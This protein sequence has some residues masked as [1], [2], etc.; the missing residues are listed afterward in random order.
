MGINMHMQQHFNK[1]WDWVKQTFTPA[2]VDEIQAYLNQSVDHADLERRIKEL[3]Q[4]GMI[5]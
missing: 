5:I 4:K 1:F 3:S 2:Y